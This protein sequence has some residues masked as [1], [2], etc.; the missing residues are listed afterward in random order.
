MKK[1]DLM[2]TRIIG[3]VDNVMYIEGLYAGDHFHSATITDWTKSD[4]ID[5]GVKEFASY[6]E[7]NQYHDKIFWEEMGN[8]VD[9]QIEES[10]DVKKLQSYPGY[11]AD[12]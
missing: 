8:A 5:R 7:L 3:I 12:L 1:E 4:L 10:E 2:S 11:L 9:K 6:I